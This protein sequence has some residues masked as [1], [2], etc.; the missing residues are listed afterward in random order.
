MAA[1]TSGVG[2]KAAVDRKVAVGGGAAGDAGGSSNDR[3]DLAIALI[4]AGGMIGIITARAL[5]RS[6][7]S[8]T[9]SSVPGG[10]PVL[11]VTGTGFPTVTPHAAQA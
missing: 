3:V 1:E 7:I 6:I 5:H 11:G 8:V 10:L 9:G 2:V 4:A